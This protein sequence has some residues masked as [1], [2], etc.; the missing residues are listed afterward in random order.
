MMG[1]TSQRQEKPNGVPSTLDADIQV[2]SQAKDTCGIPPVQGVFDSA[3]ALLT[4]IRVRSLYSAAVGFRFTFPQDPMFNK[5]DY[6][7][8][9]KLCAGVCKALN[10]GSKGRQLDELSQPVLEA[11]E[12]LT[13]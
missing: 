1:S 4:T 7:D 9:G 3:G 12:E 2:L 8:I 5:Q 10:R 11:I 6:T 13:A